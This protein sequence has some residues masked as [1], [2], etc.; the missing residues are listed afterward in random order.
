MQSD[1]AFDFFHFSV[2]G[3]ARLAQATW[4]SGL[5]AQA[6]ANVS[7]PVVSGTAQVG[8]SLSASTGI[9]S[10]SPTSFAYQ[11]TR[12]DAGGA[13]CVDVGGATASTY[14]LVAADAGA[15]MRV[16][17]TASN[18]VGSSSADSAATAVVTAAPSGVPAGFTSVVVE[19]G[20]GG[21][22]VSAITNG[23]R[24]TISGAA[25]AVDTA[26]GVKD[27]GPG[28]LSGR[29]YVR[30][31][32]ALAQGQSLSANLAVFQMRDNGGALV[33]ELYL[34]SDRSVRLYSPPGGLRSSSINLSTGV[35]VPNNGS[36]S[37]RVEVSAQANSSIIVRVDDVNRIT[38][39]GL[40]GATSGNQRYL[41]AGIDHYDGAS[42][43]GVSSEHTYV[44]T[45][46]STWLGSP[47]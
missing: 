44:A 2:T 31:V 47:T 42:G 28:G 16:R 3:Q 36:S 41:R 34:A 4:N 25:D 14:V 30:D 32:L 7:P 45:S 33:Y 13:A 19:P 15:T 27:L 39:T 40:T 10:G 17:V 8:Q 24:A 12:C 26:Y 23:L 1:H 29:V 5:F 18:S 20:C 43:Q 38:L 35:L 6:P 22:S 11:W 37:I 21:C 9:W 46:Q